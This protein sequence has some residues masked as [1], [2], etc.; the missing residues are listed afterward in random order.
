M[1]NFRWQIPH[2]FSARLTHGLKLDTVLLLLRCFVF[3][4]IPVASAKNIGKWKGPLQH[5]ELLSKVIAYVEALFRANK[6]DWV[7]FHTVRHARAVAKASQDIG[8]ACGLS[9]DDLEVVTLA[10]WFHDT[11]YLEGI[12]GHEERS[13][14]I[15]SA[16]LRGNDYPEEKIDRIAGCI[17][18]TRLPQ[19]PKSLLEQVLCDADIAHLASKDFFK[20][21]ELIR[22]EIEHRRRRRLTDEE[23]LAMNTEFVAGHQYH[24]DCARSKYDEQ[25]AANLKALKQRLTQEKEKRS[26]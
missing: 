14:R 20:V 18:A 21:T 8:A 24:T 10:A 13:I 4:G 23:W 9:E 2:P 26:S 3:R 25:H 19:N 7:K 12:D 17:R 11:G 6:P 5:K 22:S 1:Q 15:A 16:Y